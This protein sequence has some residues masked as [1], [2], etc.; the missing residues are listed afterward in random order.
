MYGFPEKRL[1]FLKFYELNKIS[2][3]QQVKD[4]MLV[5]L[6]HTSKVNNFE[7]KT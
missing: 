7:Y 3:Y 5:S 4:Y 2:I 6:F 1:K